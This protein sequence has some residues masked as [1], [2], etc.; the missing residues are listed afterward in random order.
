MRLPPILAIL[1]AAVSWGGAAFAAPSADLV[2]HRAIYSMTLGSTVG[3]SGGPASIR[4]VMSY[5]FQSRCAAWT[6]DSTVFYE[7][8]I[9]QAQRNRE[10]TQDHYLG[11]ERRFR[12]P[13]QL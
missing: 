11:R 4:G 6:V 10:R 7:D 2:P 13:I 1:P 3:S 5:E 9:W 8:E 12:I